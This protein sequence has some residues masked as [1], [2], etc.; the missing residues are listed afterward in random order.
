M[1]LIAGARLGPYRLSERSAPAAW[2]RCTGARDT[3][4]DRAVAVKMLRAEFA[5]ISGPPRALP[6]RGGR[7]RLAESSPHLHPA[8]HRPP[9][10]RRVPRDGDG[11]RGRPWPTGWCEARCRLR[12]ALGVRQDRA[13]RA[14]PAHSQGIVHRDLKPANI[15]LTRS[16][17]K[18]LDF[19]LA[20]LL[21]AEAPALGEPHAAPHS[22]RRERSSAPSSAHGARAAR[23]QAHRRA[24][25]P[26]CLRRD[27]LRDGHRPPRF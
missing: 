12:E 24:H 23:R 17:V 10:R 18:L 5:G 2:E 25:G 19:G 13:P 6:A 7:H 11:S 22:P 27:P 16:G 8:R 4:L 9:G 21:E 20:R 15:M 14:R 26:V 3:R 1:S